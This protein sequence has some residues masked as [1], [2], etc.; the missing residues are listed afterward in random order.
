VVCNQVGF[1]HAQ[2][3]TSDSYFGLV[4]LPFS[5]QVVVCSGDESKLSDCQS[6]NYG[7]FGEGQGAGVICSNY[8]STNRKIFNLK[9]SKIFIYFT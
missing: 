6:T 7:C 2:H 5:Y 9:Y 8:S 3:L 4:S 1:R